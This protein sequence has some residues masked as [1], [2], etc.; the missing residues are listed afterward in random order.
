MVM[1]MLLEAV[2]DVLTFE[3]APPYISDWGT[4]EFATRAA[5]APYCAKRNVLAQ[6]VYLCVL[7]C[8]SGKQ[9]AVTYMSYLR[10]VVLEG[11]L[12]LAGLI[13]ATRA[14]AVSGI[15]FRCCCFLG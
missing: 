13:L 14:R 15:H 7:Y 2:G 5:L 9:R 12:L 4:E 10:N 8:Q 6:A 3:K 11:R 1:L